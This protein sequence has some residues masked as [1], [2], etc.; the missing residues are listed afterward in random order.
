MPHMPFHP[1]EQEYSEEQLARG[2]ELYDTYYG[3]SYAANYR[4]QFGVGGISAEDRSYIRAYAKT[5]EGKSRFGGGILSRLFGKRHGKGALVGTFDSYLKKQG[6]SQQ[7]ALSFY[8][9][10]DKNPEEFFGKK[11]PH[12]KNE[13]IRFLKA[14]FKEAQDLASAAATTERDMM[15]EDRAAREQ[16]EFDKAQREAFDLSDEEQGEVASRR[17]KEQQSKQY[18]ESRGGVTSRQAR[19][20]G[21]VMIPQARPM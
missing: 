11:M 17:R 6:F 15:R 16:A 19:S 13:Q 9:E 18:L 4:R 21:L 3:N 10:L 8:E 2:K 14:Y 5:P 1:P 12:E 20:A 7:E